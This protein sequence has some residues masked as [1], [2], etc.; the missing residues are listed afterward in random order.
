[1]APPWT[2]GFNRISE[3]PIIVAE[4]AKVDAI[5]AARESFA[6]NSIIERGEGRR[7]GAGNEEATAVD[8]L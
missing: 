4:D 7:G 2:G 3:I 1:L 5:D 6:R 8:Y